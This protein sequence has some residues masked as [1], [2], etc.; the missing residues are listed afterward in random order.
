MAI[1]AKS[2]KLLWTASG[3]RCAFPDCWERLCIHEAKDAAPFTIGEMAHICGDK[4]GSNRYDSTQSETERNDYS[5]LIL[6]CPNHHMLIDKKE[7]EGIFPAIKLKEIK[8]KHE[9]RVLTLMESD[10]N[11][12]KETISR[13]ILPLLEENRQS[14]HHYGPRSELAR[15]QPHNA[16]VYAVWESERLSIIVPNNRKIRTLL[17]KNILIYSENEIGIINKFFAHVR[18]Y[19]R[20]VQDEIPYAAVVRFPIE[21]D[22]FIRESANAGAQ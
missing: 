3:G 12:D 2:I 15:T 7:N 18:S 16:A 19:E 1:T 4:P 8:T 11:P 5:N 9:E 6:L 17:N 10:Q 13:K 22:N 14:W 20:W 21:F